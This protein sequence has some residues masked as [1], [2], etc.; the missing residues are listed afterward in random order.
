MLRTTLSLS[1]ALCGAALGL[2]LAAADMEFVLSVGQ[3]YGL[4]WIML[5]LLAGLYLTW[6]QYRV[7]QS[8]YFEQ[9]TWS[10]TAAGVIGLVERSWYYPPMH[11]WIVGIGAGLI[12]LPIAWAAIVE[13]RSVVELLMRPYFSLGIFVT[14]FV[15]GALGGYLTF[16]MPL[17][18]RTI[19]K[20]LIKT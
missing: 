17:T 2:R 1:I 14:G 19:Q 7:P 11:L 20:F 5:G 15:Y 9:L 16:A 8:R 3:A 10:G 4:L 12:H 13:N 18:F 6:V